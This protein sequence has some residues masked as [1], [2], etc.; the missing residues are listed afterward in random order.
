MEFF[1]RKS[2]CHVVD[3]KRQ[4]VSLLPDLHIPKILYRTPRQKLNAESQSLTALKKIPCRPGDL[5]G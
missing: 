5:Q 4:L 1:L 2:S 3:A